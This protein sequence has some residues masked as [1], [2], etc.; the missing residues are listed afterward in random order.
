VFEGDHLAPRSDEAA[1]RMVQML[2][3]E[4]D[5]GQIG[6][7]L[8]VWVEQGLEDHFMKA[9]ERVA[10]GVDELPGERCEGEGAAACA[11]CEGCRAVGSVGLRA[12]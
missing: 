11:E 9:N 7:P 12:L 10:R 2:R 6:L 1:L 5:K 3:G 4:K 8:D